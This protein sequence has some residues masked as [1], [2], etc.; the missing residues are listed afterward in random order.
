MRKVALLIAVLVLTGCTRARTQ[1]A[2]PLLGNGSFEG[3]TSRSAVYWTLH[4]GPF[5]TQFNEVEGP[6]GWTAWWREGFLCSGTSD[7]RTGRPEVKVISGPDMAR[8]RSGKKAVQWFTFYRCHEGGLLQR[9]TVEPG[10]YY[11]FSV[12]GH[13]WFSR[14]SHKPHDPPYDYDCKTRIYWAQDYLSIGIDPTGGIDPA[15]PAVEWGKEQQIYGRYDEALKTRRIQAQGDT[16][17]VFVKSEAS[18]PLKHCDSYFD[19]AL[20]RDVTYQMFLPIVM[21]EKR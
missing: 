7:W 19:D 1:Q 9:V 11:T 15:S 12:Y 2:E 20:L 17:T 16:I 10:H 5:Y 8:I 14:C 3:D 4:G 13:A 6:E 21:L 18:H